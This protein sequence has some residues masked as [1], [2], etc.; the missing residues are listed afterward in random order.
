[1]KNHTWWRG[2]TK[3][4]PARPGSLVD[5]GWK[6]FMFGNSDIGLSIACSEANAAALLDYYRLIGLSKDFQ[7]SNTSPNSARME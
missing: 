1:M 3:R 6:E 7:C 5:E 2:V 4:V